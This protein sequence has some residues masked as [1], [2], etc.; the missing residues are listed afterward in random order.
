MIDLIAR[1]MKIKYYTKR[2]HILSLRIIYRIVL[3]VNFFE[4]LKLNFFALLLLYVTWCMMWR[5]YMAYVSCKQH[6]EIFSEVSNLQFHGHHLYFRKDFQMLLAVK[7][8]E[9]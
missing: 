9:L 7:G 4:L 5:L 1:Y 8:G 3:V 6:L 2:V